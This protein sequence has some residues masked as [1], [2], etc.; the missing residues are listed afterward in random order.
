MANRNTIVVALTIALF[1]ATSIFAQAPPP[2]PPGVALPPSYGA[3]AAPV[4]TGRIAKFLMNPNGDVDGLLLGDG[5]QV[6]FPPHLSAALMQI[7][8]VGDTV[9][10]QGFRGYGGDAVHAAV[11]TNTGSAQSMVDQ[12]PSPDRPPPA[13]AALIALNA[14]GRVV[15]LLHADMGELNGAILE[16]G[17]IVRFPPPFGAQLQTALRPNVQL[18]ATGYGT[19]NAYGRALEATS[20]SIDGQAP[21]PVYGPGPGLMPPVLGVAP[22][23][24]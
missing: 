12:P 24:R 16:D 1:P 11:I 19:Q 21:I 13:P 4:A 2:P 10:V 6:N 18:T 17:T 14:N 9:S 15:R 20:L 3:A 23:P 8:R 22:R 7:A 5:T